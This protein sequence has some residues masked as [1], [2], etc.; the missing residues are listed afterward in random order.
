MEEDLK[1]VYNALQLAKVHGLEA[2]VVLSA[3]YEIKSD[4]D[5][6]IKDALNIALADWDI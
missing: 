4:D 5:L 3:L 2:E 1:I 6:D